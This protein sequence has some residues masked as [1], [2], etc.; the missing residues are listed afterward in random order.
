[1]ANPS[2]PNSVHIVAGNGGLPCVQVRHPVAE[3][4]LYLQGAHLT[5]FQ[6][7]GSQP[8]LFLSGKSLF[9][10]G[11][12]IRGGVPL[13]FPWFGARQDDPRS[14][15]HGFARNLPW[16]LVEATASAEGVTLRLRLESGPQTLAVWAHPFVA[17]FEVVVGRKLGLA[18]SV[19]NP[20]TEAFQFEEALHTYFQ[21][22]DVRTVRVTG[23]ENTVFL[24]K[25]DGF[26]RKQE[27]TE[28][29]AIT[30]ET[31]RIYLETESACVIADAGRKIRIG[32]SGSR[33][34][35]LW[36][37]WVAK[38]AAMADFGD[39]EWPSMLCIETAN[40]QPAPVTLTP[41]ATHRMTAEIEVHPA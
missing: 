41:C 30:A 3:A 29:I 18:F 2:L 21:V 34:T 37:P 27:G 4:D 26:A 35:V 25:T 15:M 13:I 7:A 23:L 14:P 39:D 6:P 20:G 11:K 12:P 22:A 32:K 1:M 16:E 17:E 19:S 31:D 38:S 40:T 33:S 9:A 8:V 10:E 36:N 24:D 28:P 5:H